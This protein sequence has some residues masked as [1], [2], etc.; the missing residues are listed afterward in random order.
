M[1]QVLKGVWSTL[2]GLQIIRRV[3]QTDTRT[4]QVNN[5]SRESPRTV[6]EGASIQLNT[7]PRRPD[8]SKDQSSSRQS[9]V[10]ALVAIFAPH[11]NSSKSPRP[12]PTSSQSN[13]SRNVATRDASASQPSATAP[14]LSVEYHLP[15]GY[16]ALPATANI[17][18][19]SAYLQR[20]SRDA[21]S[22][23]ASG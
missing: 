9:F 23:A 14:D 21:G 10:T 2:V 3:T 7:G 6:R 4:V 12:W 17:A 16:A 19:T 13:D 5:S 15:D 8:T 18:R 1:V 11:L 22:H 20:S